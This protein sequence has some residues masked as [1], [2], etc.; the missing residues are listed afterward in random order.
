MGILRVGILYI[1][2]SVKMP[3]L[4]NASF[5][6]TNALHALRC[7]SLLQYHYT[8][9][10]GIL[11]KSIELNILVDNIISGACP[12]CHSLETAATCDIKS[13]S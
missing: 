6:D 9:A 5:F 12:D 4:I 10:L 1:K 3:T 8:L 13:S 7:S 2:H 11:N